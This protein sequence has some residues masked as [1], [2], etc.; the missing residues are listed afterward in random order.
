MVAVKTAQPRTTAPA[1]PTAV[2][3]RRGLKGFI[4]ALRYQTE[5]SEFITRLGRSCAPAHRNMSII[6][7]QIPSAEERKAVLLSLSLM[8][9]SPR[10][11][12]AES[13]WFRIG[14]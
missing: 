3:I 10:H 4:A 9:I 5:P 11:A 7:F 12:F 2:S 6:S 14:E 13:E 1:N 8:E